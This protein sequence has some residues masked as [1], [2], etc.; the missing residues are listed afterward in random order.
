MV[1][2]DLRLSRW[3]AR[4]SLPGEVWWRRRESNPWKGRLSKASSRLCQSLI[5]VNNKLTC[6]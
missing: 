4:C 1:F 5:P 6:P 2:C 3:Q